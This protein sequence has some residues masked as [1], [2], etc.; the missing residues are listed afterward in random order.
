MKFNI[1]SIQEELMD[2][3]IIDKSILFKNLKELEFINRFTGGPVLGFDAIRQ[4]VGQ[5]TEELHIADIGYGAGDMLAYII[6]HAHRLPCPVKLTGIDLMPEALEY[7]QQEH[8]KLPEQVSFETCDYAEWF[9]KGHQPDIIHAGL[10]CHH[11][12]DNQLVSFLRQAAE[13]CTIGVVINDLERSPIAYY[14]IKVLTQLFSR[15][16]FTKNDAPL[17]VLRGFKKREWKT[18][19]EEAGI[20]D[21]SIQW[22]W[23]FRH[24]VTFR[25]QSKQ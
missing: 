9:D 2:H 4:M 16:A 6:K 12:K 1:R 24:L 17:S 11:L 21:Y 5:R 14:N 8:P 23:A 20:D 13:N 7:V 25:K 10:F 18:Y 3:P 15:S 22:K 19:L